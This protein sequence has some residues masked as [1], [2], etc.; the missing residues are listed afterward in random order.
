VRFVLLLALFGF[1]AVGSERVHSTPADALPEV[2]LSSFN[3]E[4]DPAVLL[5]CAFALIAIGRFHPRRRNNP[6]N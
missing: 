5:A 6:Q 1:F 4:P 3:S 2:S